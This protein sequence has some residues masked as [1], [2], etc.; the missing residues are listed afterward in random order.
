MRDN[1]EVHSANILLLAVNSLGFA[2]HRSNERADTIVYIQSGLAVGKAIK[3][4]A[5]AFA[6]LLCYPHVLHVLTIKQ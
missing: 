2:K 3:K 5:K 4:L 1:H 6:F